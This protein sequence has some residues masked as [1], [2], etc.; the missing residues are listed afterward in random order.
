MNKIKN[1]IRF[2]LKEF[3]RL[4]GYQYVDNSIPKEKSE[5]IAILLTCVFATVYAACSAVLLFGT[6]GVATNTALFLNFFCFLQVFCSLFQRHKV[7]MSRKNK[8]NKEYIEAY[9]K[10]YIEKH[11]L[12]D[13]CQEDIFERISATQETEQAFQSDHLE[14]LKPSSPYLVRME[15]YVFFSICCFAVCIIFSLALSA[16]LFIENGQKESILVALIVLTMAIWFLAVIVV[17]VFIEQIVA[18]FRA[19]A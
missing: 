9:T 17:D 6:K 13:T 10:S 19:E 16:S 7:Y 12:T 4:L 3:L 11:S 5:K 15:S 14:E 2:F 8:K 18:W 1:L